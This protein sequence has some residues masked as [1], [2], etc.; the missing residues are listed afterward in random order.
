M[1]VPLELVRDKFEKVA[2]ARRELQAA[3]KLAKLKGLDWH[4]VGATLGM[5]WG[6]AM[7]EF[8]EREADD[9]DGQ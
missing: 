3:V 6:E 9:T 4:E 5:T 7:K 2:Q 8:S 1:D